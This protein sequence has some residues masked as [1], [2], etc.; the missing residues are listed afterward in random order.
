MDEKFWEGLFIQWEAMTQAADMVDSVLEE[1]QEDMAHDLQYA[2]SHFD[3]YIFLEVEAL[4]RFVHRDHKAPVIDP[5][6][7][8]HA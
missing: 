3:S 6:C 1:E 2:I 7:D 5:Y 4:H 8:F